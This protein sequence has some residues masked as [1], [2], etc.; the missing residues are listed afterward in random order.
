MKEDHRGKAESKEIF[1][2]EL[3]E[4][5][6]EKIRGHLQELLEQEVTE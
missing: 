3:E 6:R 2:A 1:Y 4:F 5:A